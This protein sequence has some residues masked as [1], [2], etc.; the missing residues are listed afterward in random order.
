MSSLVRAAALVT[1]VLAAA[2]TA[3]VAAV[4]NVTCPATPLPAGKHE[5]EISFDGLDRYGGKRKTHK[6]EE[7]EEDENEKGER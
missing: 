3:P 5:F 2:A 6:E 1:V 4:R 7:E